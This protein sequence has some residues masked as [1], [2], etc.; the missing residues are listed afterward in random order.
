MALLSEGVSAMDDMAELVPY[1]EGWTTYGNSARKW[2]FTT[3]RGE[4]KSLCGKWQKSPFAI[5][6][7]RLD[8]DEGSPTS[9][10]CKE[11]R[12]RLD[13]RGPR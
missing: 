13:K 5:M 4:F 7:P 9:N 12:R 11:C 6:D 2:H 1:E 10:E 3:D 8:P